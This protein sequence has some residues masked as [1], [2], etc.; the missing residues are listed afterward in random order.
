VTECRGYYESGPFD[1]RGPQ[2][3]PTAVATLMRELASG[4]P[5]SHPVLQG[6]GWW[7]RPG[8]FLAKPVA[9]RTAV[10]DI[11]E[12]GAFR[13]TFPQP[14]LITGA[15]GTLGRA[16]ARICERRNLAYHVLTRQEMDIA[17]PASVEAAIVRFKPWAIINA[18]GYVR[19]DDAE[20]DVE[21]CMREN[22][23]GPT[24]LALAAIRHA[25]RFMTFSSDL[26]FDGTLD[27]PYVESDKVA[28]LGVYGRS[29]ADAE[30][31]VLDSDPQALVIRTSAFF[32]PWDEHNFVTQALDALDGGRPFAAA[33]DQI[34]SPTYVPDLV[35]TCLDLLIDRECGL[36]HL[37]NGASMSWADLARKACAA[38]GVDDSRLDARTTDE[39]GLRA[40]RPRNS[41]M[42]SERGLLLPSFDDALT[43][44]LRE[45]ELLAQRAND[46]EPA[47]YA[48]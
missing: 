19:V 27:R 48:S 9:T 29:K 18:G 21:R 44:Y 24:V 30:R 3:R 42:S 39:L 25:L 15:T 22:A 37:T 16:F 36:W 7:R 35:N 26:V 45:R 8:R 20:G 33:S 41:A 5:L 14:I 2:P 4:R 31:R 6:Q 34:V 1:V 11:A 40:A 10:A 12:R 47:H 13:S 17:D 46:V 23:H 38:A 28:P 43:R 32:G